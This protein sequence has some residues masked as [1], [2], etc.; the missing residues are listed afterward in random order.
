MSLEAIA[1]NTPINEVMNREYPNLSSQF[2][3]V[4]KKVQKY[5]FR[6][7]FNEA[8][9]YASKL[10]P[11]ETSDI[12]SRFSNEKNQE[13]VDRFQKTGGKGFTLIELLVVVAIIGI[14]AALLA[15]PVGEA[16][17]KGN[18]A[19][20]AFNLKNIGGALTRY[21]LDYDGNYPFYESPLNVAS[22]GLIY[23]GGY[24]D[25]PGTF[26]CPADKETK[27]PTTIVIATP[28]YNDNQPRMSYI[29]SF[30]VQIVRNGGQVINGFLVDS[31]FPIVYDWY[32]GLEN[33][34]GTAGQ[35]TIANHLAKRN[36]KGGGN[37]LHIGG[38]V[39]WREDSKWSSTGN[40]V[41]PDPT[42][43]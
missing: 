36:L 42:S 37:I 33:G 8:V 19:G 10:D 30:D 17:E 16:I 18:R 5:L 31:R 9:N 38:D 34:E 23:I 3:N 6:N 7:N 32:A 27:K 43:Q 11:K 2:Y 13:L 22:L 14:L 4:A 26:R 40:N 39:E 15:G 1:L 12:T 21:M 25:T 28:G 35:R 41:F 20:C 29:D 24:I